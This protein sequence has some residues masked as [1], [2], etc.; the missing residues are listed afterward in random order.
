MLVNINLTITGERVVL[1]PYRQEHVPVYHEWMVSRA[2]L[3][4]IV[5]LGLHVDFGASLHHEG[6]F[7]Q[8]DPALQEATASEPLTIEARLA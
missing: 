4:P 1:V 2:V 6:I 7:V 8:E 3:W 5:C